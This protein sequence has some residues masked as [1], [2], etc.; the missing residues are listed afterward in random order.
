[1]RLCRRCA[2]L[3]D[4]GEDL[5]D[6]GWVGDIRDDPQCAGTQWAEGHVEFE[7]AF[8]ALGPGE[9]RGFGRFHVVRTARLIGRIRLVGAWLEQFAGHEPRA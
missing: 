8:K 2:G 7:R 6:D 3:A 4:V 9:S 1:M 5:V